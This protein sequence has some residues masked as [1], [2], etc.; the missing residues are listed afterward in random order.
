VWVLAYPGS[1]ITR[2]DESVIATWG[3]PDLWRAFRAIGI[4]LLHTGPVKLS[5]GIVR[6]EYTPTIDGWFDRISLEIDP[7]LGTE[8]EYRRMVQVARN[9]TA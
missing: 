8:E 2:A 1:V 3:D 7:A 5:G 9:R 4:D 6:R